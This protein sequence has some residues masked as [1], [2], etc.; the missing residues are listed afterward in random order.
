MTTIS[1]KFAD[2]H[3]EEIEVTEEFKKEYEFLLVQEYARDRREL[4]QKYRAGL[5]CTKDLSLDE[6]AENGYELPS[7]MLDPL[8]LLIEREERREYYEKLLLPLTERQREVY[9][10]KLQGLTQ[11]QIADKLGLAIGSV[12]ERLQNAEKRILVNYF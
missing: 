2:G 8:E 9:I 11:T 3:V 10:L 7:G 5:R 4:Q 12:N 6:F 1:Y